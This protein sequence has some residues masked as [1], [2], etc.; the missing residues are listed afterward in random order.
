MKLVKIL[1][2]SENYDGYLTYGTGYENQDTC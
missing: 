2:N 1:T